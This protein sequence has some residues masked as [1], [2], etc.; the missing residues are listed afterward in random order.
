VRLVRGNR[1]RE[2]LGRG[3]EE[4]GGGVAVALVLICDTY[5]T[6]PRGFFCKNYDYHLS[7]SALLV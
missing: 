6:I 5:L 7:I 2:M 4:S 1:L 3:C